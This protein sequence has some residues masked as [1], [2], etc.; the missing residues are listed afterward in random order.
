MSSSARTVEKGSALPAQVETKQATTGAVPAAICLEAKNVSP[1]GTQLAATW[2]PA[3]GHGSLVMGVPEGLTA[4]ELEFHWLY[5]PFSKLVHGTHLA[6]ARGIADTGLQTRAIADTSNIVGTEVVFMAGSDIGNERYGRFVFSAPASLLLTMRDD[7]AR[8]YLI[9][10][11]DYQTCSASRILITK[12]KPPV[13]WDAYDP[14]KL[15]GPWYVDGSGNH[16]GLLQTERGITPSRRWGSWATSELSHIVEFMLSED[17]LEGQVPRVL[18][19]SLLQLDVLPTHDNCR[20]KHKCPDEDMTDV[21]MAHKQVLRSG[22]LKRVASVALLRSITEL[23]VPMASD[24][25]A[26]ADA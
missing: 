7:G 4:D 18:R 16:F 20:H 14:T 12:G 25:A 9:E 26:A 5:S 1:Y 19:P 6:A 8:F 11:V 23:D 3:D 24:A 22:A 15:G 21:V 17:V 13:K 2:M 10:V